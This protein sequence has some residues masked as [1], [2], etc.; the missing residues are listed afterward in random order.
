[1]VTASFGYL[2]PRREDYKPTQIKR[3]AGLAQKQL[4]ANA[5]SEVY[6]YF[7]HEE[8]CVGPEFAKSLQKH[9]T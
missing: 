2:R 8:T 5:W 1:M 4:Q 3:W 9:L 6:A 7:K